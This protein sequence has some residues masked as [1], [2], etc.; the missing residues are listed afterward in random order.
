MRLYL[1]LDEPGKSRGQGN[2]SFRYLPVYFTPSYSSIC[3]VL[4]WLTSS[5][6]FV[7]TSLVHYVK[8]T[9]QK[10]G[11]QFCDFKI[12]TYMS[13]WIS[14]TIVCSRPEGGLRCRLGVK[15][16]LKAKLNI[17]HNHSLY[18]WVRYNT[19]PGWECL[20]VLYNTTSDPLYSDDNGFRCVIHICRHV[21]S[22]ENIKRIVQLLW[23]L[24]G[25]MVTNTSVLFD[26]QPPHS[27]H[28][29]LGNPSRAGRTWPL[30]TSYS[31]P[32]RHALRPN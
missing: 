14:C 13:Y 28:S 12:R 22:C 8:Q 11:Q 21:I 1:S 32:T 16:L 2:W 20:Q 18:S 5:N 15:L 9:L 25:P 4:Y 17:S 29:L 19:L 26:G 30:V 23:H 6:V 3:D 7:L 24:N 27:E 10:L 31:W